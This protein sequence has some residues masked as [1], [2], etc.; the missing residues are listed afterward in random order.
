MNFTLKNRISELNKLAEELEKFSS[1]YKLP[2]KI[3]FDINLSLDELVTNII[4]YGYD[5]D[6]DHDILISIAKEE[7]NIFITLEDEGIEFNPLNTEEPETETELEDREIGGLGIYF[8]KNK[9]DRISYERIGGRN[10]LK[11]E[12]QI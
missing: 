11:L 4:S 1:E 2:Q 6:K 10:I 8:V 7:D 3:L 12:K 9:M 5:D